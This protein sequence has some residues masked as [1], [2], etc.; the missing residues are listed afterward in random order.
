MNNRKSKATLVLVVITLILVTPAGVYLCSSIAPV[1][2]VTATAEHGS[3]THN[4]ELPCLIAMMLTAETT[5][6][7]LNGFLSMPF[8]SAGKALLPALSYFIF[9]HQILYF[10]SI[11]LKP[12]PSTPPPIYAG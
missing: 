1:I 12:E 6:S 9:A 5:I 2:S 10:L 11:G 4:Y 7:G 3:G 8:S